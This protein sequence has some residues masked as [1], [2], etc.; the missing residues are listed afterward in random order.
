[1]DL[2][3]HTLRLLEV[4]GVWVSSV[5]TVAA[6][7]VALMLAWDANRVKLDVSVNVMQI[8]PSTPQ[9]ET[10]LVRVCNINPRPATIQSI[11]WRAGFLP[12]GPFKYKHFYQA[13][14]SRFDPST[15][16]P[17][18]LKDGD[19][20]SFFIEPVFIETMGE[21]LNNQIYRSTLKVRICTTRG[22]VFK[23]RPAS[24]FMLELN[25]RPFTTSS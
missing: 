13:H 2:S 8:I 1:M 6:V 17:C 10:I 7:I 16:L 5:G 19:T 9:R 18:E 20:A 3:E 23:K 15:K 22:E 4:A 12:F 21:S 11:T 25:A 24:N 14:Y